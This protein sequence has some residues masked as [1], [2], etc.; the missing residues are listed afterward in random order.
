MSP[1]PPRC[2]GSP[3]LFGVND[4]P[5][6]RRCL[7]VYRMQFVTDAGGSRKGIAFLD[8]ARGGATVASRRPGAAEFAPDAWVAIPIPLALDASAKGETRQSGTKN[9][10]AL[11][12]VYLYRLT[13]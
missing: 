3:L 13:E 4:S 9:V 12:R 11:G 6:A 8:V 5:D 7:V 2:G 10:I 1:S